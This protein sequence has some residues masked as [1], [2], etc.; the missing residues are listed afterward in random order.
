MSAVTDKG[1]DSDAG[2]ML[3]YSDKA[4]QLQKDIYDQTRSDYAPYREAGTTALSSLMQK[5]GLSGDSSASDYGSLSKPYD[6][7]AIL[8]DDPGYQFRMDEGNKAVSRQLAASGKYLTP[9][10]S[11]ALTEYGQ[12][13]ASN[14]FNNA[15][16][17]NQI[18][19]DTIYNRLAGLTG[20]GQSATGS[21]AAAGQNYANASGDIYTQQGNAVT[22]AAEA[23]RNR[24]SSFFNTLAGLGGKLGAAAIMSDRRLKENIH[25]IGKENG[26]NIYEFNYK[27]N[28][29]SRYIGVMAQEVAGQ[30]PDAVVVGDNGFM[31][32]D[33]GRIGVKFREAAYAS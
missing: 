27:G 7:S 33:Y 10:A 20:T 2:P 21:S 16:N 9:E 8:A 23:A 22:A 30:R 5:L 11:K 15:Y 17:R 13:Y 29:E 31:A 18:N 24:S 28:P 19:T 4:L 12:N 6:A 3:A 1:G 25:H 14:E 26:H 32:V